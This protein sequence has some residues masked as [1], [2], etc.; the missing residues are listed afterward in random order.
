MSQL[1]LSRRRMIGSMSAAA[2]AGSFPAWG[3][4]ARRPNI[5]FILADDL[6]Y[7]DLGC[8]DSRHISTPVLDDLAKQGVK[9]TD[10]YANSPV[11]SPTR[12]SLATGRYNRF[13]P[14]GLVEPFSPGEWGETAIP[15]GYDTYMRLLQK[16]GYRTSLIGKWH[17]GPTAA[18]N[19]LNFGFDDFY[20]F[21]GGGIDYFTHE[22]GSGPALME[23]RAD[24]DR[25]GY[26][27]T[28]LANEA[29]G[30]IADAA[31]T[32]KPFA[33]SLH[34]NA[35]HW[36][37]EG[38]EDFALGTQGGHNDGGSLDVY[39]EMVESLDRNIGRVL[40][41]LDNHGMAEDTLVIFTSD[42]GGERYS[43]VWPF[44]GTKG[45][46]LEGGIRV[47]AIVRYPRAIPG[48]RETDQIALTMDYYP[49]IL[50]AAGVNHDHVQLDGIS[51]LE[52]LRDGRTVD[53]K[54]FWSFQGHDQ[55]AARDRNWKYFS[56]EGN[57]FLFDLSR[58]PHERANRRRAEPEIFTRL[59]DE[60][61]AWDANMAPREGLQG[62]CE[63]PRAQALAL[64]KTDVS[65]CKVY[66]ATPPSAG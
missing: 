10:A 54:V 31:A 36:P 28:L 39:A 43:E 29:I 17:L 41:E 53:R 3:Q 14:T 63:D 32:G 19:P 50:D 5:L 25:E 49:T 33:I 13:F 4:V 64:P 8:Y 51:L 38:P 24:I 26:M 21:L 12:L 23:D 62:Y 47:P 15:P 7:A 65:N 16:A 46:L 58:D 11:C 18:G 55:A 34:F 56:V 61:R 42:N 57:E 60:W 2:T 22:Y 27:T 59:R 35:P 52:L 9:M 66:V 40:T 44:R 45:Y 1:Y 48:G 20:G 30:R 37:W 6:G